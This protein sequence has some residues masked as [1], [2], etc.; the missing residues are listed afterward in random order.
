MNKDLIKNVV[1][2]IIIVG[3]LY[4]LQTLVYKFIGFDL[5][6][7]L[8]VKKEE[9]KDKKSM[10]KKNI[11]ISN[12]KKFERMMKTLRANKKKY[13]KKYQQNQQPQQTQQTQQQQ[14]QQKLQQLSISPK[15]PLRKTYQQTQQQPQQKLQ[16]L[17]ISPKDHC[18]KCLNYIES[19][20]S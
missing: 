8:K 11:E 16:Q 7:I 13:E 3:T 14:P 12:R 4:F 2:A 20:L 15:E 18:N 10:I 1:L 9:F 5:W 19:N 6:D 17:S